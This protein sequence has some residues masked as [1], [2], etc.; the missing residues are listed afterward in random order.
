MT[1]TPIFATI[2]VSM[3]PQQPY[4]PNAPQQPQGPYPPQP[5][6]YGYGTPATPRFQQHPSGQY[7]VL[8]PPQAAPNDG[9]SGHNP[10]EFIVSP[11]S[12][13][14][15]G[16]GASLAGGS[17]ILRIGLLAGGFIVILIVAAVA[18]TA[19]TPKGSLPSFISVAQ[20]QQEIIRIA[21]NATQQAQSQDA[22]NFVANVQ[23]SVTSDQQAVI[24]YL[25]AKGTKLGATQLAL[26]KSTQVDAQLANAATANNFDS[27]IAQ[28]MT[29]EL[30]NYQSSLKTTYGQ[31]SSA[32]AKLMLQK[33]YNSAT[34]LLKQASA[35]SAEF[36]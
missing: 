2:N 30:Q 5:P 19:F 31:T 36:Q 29:S 23:A 27:A 1:F 10:Y 22:Q 20:R 17:F 15:K 13:G 16:F 11:N 35:L 6:Q 24:T 8:A 3:P 28:T 26:D 33:E 12:S 7:E 9:H 4:Q 25:S 14:K 18:I 32:Q 34:L 21:T